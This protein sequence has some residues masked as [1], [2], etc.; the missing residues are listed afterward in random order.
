MR[1]PIIALPDTSEG[2]HV[3]AFGHY[4]LFPRRLIKMS[5]GESLP[6]HATHVVSSEAIKIDGASR[7]TF[8]SGSFALY[9]LPAR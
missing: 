3:E 4:Y 9:K 8:I 2:R 5:P 6:A 1:T 7:V